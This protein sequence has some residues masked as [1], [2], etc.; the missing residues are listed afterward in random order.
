[1]PT[2]G[3]PPEGV[4]KVVLQIISQQVEQVRQRMRLPS[5]GDAFAHWY[6]LTRFRMSD[7]EASEAISMSGPNDKGLDAVYLDDDTR[8]IYCFQ[9]K[10]SDEGRASFGYEAATKLRSTIEFLFEKSL[11]EKVVSKSLYD[12][13]TSVH[14]RRDAG[15]DLVFYL[16]ILGSIAPE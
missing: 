10:Y 1:M 2:Y 6:L 5:K 14:E 16:V 4:S 12:A 9:F 7:L 8:Q 13:L 3:M 11:I 15:Y